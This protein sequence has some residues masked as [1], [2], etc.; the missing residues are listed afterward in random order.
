[1]SATAPARA[2]RRSAAC[3]M[4][5]PS[6]ASERAATAGTRSNT[7][8]ARAMWPATCC[9][10]KSPRMPPRR[11]SLLRPSLPQLNPPSPPMDIRSLA[12]LRKKQP[13][14][15]QVFCCTP[16][17]SKA[18]HTL[19]NLSLTRSSTYTAPKPSPQWATRRAISSIPAS[20]AS[21]PIR[22]RWNPLPRSTSI[23]TPPRIPH[24]PASTAATPLTPASAATAMTARS[25][26]LPRATTIR[27][28]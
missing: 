3:T 28:R 22:I 6:P 5:P 9:P 13:A 12:V 1:M 23:N 26:Y 21:T 11:Q 25:Q 16:V 10:T 7:R 17:P 15:R 4:A 20:C 19:R 18:A 27:R 2:I 14:M 24:P 8:A